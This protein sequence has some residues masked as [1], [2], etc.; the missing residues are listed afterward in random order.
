MFTAQ[1]MARDMI[2]AGLR[3]EVEQIHR[4]VSAVVAELPDDRPDPSEP[5]P[6]PSHDP[7]QP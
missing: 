1:A 3:D 5:P 6:E 7:S 2:A 4:N